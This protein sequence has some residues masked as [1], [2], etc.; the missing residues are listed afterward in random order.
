MSSLQPETGITTR[1]NVGTFAFIAALGVFQ[2]LLHPEKYSQFEAV[3]VIASVILD[4]ARAVAVL[5]IAAHIF[6]EF[7]NRFVTDLFPIRSLEY[8]EAIAALLVFSM[9]MQR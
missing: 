7:W 3:G 1:F 9:L 8:R 6:R 4:A 5:L 2:F